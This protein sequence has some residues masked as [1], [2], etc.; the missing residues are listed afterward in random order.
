M[1]VWSMKVSGGDSQMVKV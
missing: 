1:S